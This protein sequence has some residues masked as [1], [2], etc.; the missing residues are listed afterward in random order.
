MLREEY[1]DEFQ[2][3]HRPWVTAM[4]FLEHLRTARAAPNL[5]EILSVL[6]GTLPDKSTTAQ[7]WTSTRNIRLD[8]FN[9]RAASILGVASR[10]TRSTAPSDYTKVVCVDMSHLRTD[11]G[12]PIDLNAEESWIVDYLFPHVQ[13]RKVWIGPRTLTKIQRSVGALGLPARGAR[14]EYHLRAHLSLPN[15]A[16]H[17]KAEQFCAAMHC[18][19]D[20]RPLKSA[21]DTPS[22]V[23]PRW[24]ADLW[25]P[26]V[27]ARA[28]Q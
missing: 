4:S 26:V 23:Y 8:A 16:E 1:P 17:D 15:V 7:W 24:C 12:F 20:G 6:H 14:P 28:V 21:W 9:A 2:N 27:G 5:R 25:L 13:A 10:Y 22:A 19:D 3:I 11:N 18:V